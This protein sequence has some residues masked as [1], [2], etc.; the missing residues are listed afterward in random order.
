MNAVPILAQR[1]CAVAEWWKI[2]LQ[3]LK[4]ICHCVTI[5]PFLIGPFWQGT[6][7]YFGCIDIT[8]CQI[9]IQ[10]GAASISLIIV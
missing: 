4:K 10:N 9:L 3:H 7:K 1:L 2:N 5:S 8:K 6:D